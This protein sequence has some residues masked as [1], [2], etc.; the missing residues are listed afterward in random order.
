MVAWGESACTVD[1]A[2]LGDQP[3]ENGGETASDN[4]IRLAD[5][6]GV[7]WV[8]FT[9]KCVGVTNFLRT[10]NMSHLIFLTSVSVCISRM[11]FWKL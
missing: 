10:L 8:L 7:P 4:I 2:V 1:S 3:P 6:K 5:R 11:C 9:L